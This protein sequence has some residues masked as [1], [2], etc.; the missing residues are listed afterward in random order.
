VRD[1][2]INRRGAENTEG[3]E[4]NFYNENNPKMAAWL[5]E[6]IAAGLIA[7]GIVDERSITEIRHDEIAEYRQCHFFAG[8]G[9]WS[10]ALR[11][12]GWDDDRPVW[13]ASLPCQP[14]SAAGDGAGASDS[15]NLWPAFFGL[16]QKLKPECVFGEQV[17]AAIKLGW[18]DGEDGRA[19]RL[20]HAG[21]AGPRRTRPSRHH[22]SNATARRCQFKSME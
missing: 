12:A 13:T 7:P 21:C 15:R 11:L 1:E 9:G 14:W 18:L 2:S 10:Y 19:E 6:L 20:V 8:I 5:R 4:V 17:E 22:S 16:F 3:D